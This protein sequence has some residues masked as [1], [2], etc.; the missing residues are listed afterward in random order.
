MPVGKLGYSLG[1]KYL[2]GE[3][4]LV[5]AEIHIHVHYQSMISGYYH[6]LVY[7]SPFRNRM[8]AYFPSGIYPKA[9]FAIS[10]SP[11]IAASQLV[12]AAWLDWVGKR[13]KHSAGQLK[14]VTWLK[15]GEWFATTRL[16]LV[17]G[18]SWVPRCLKNLFIPERWFVWFAGKIFCA[19]VQVE[20]FFRFHCCFW[21]LGLHVL[22]IYH[23]FLPGS[24]SLWS[25]WFC[26]SWQEYEAFYLLSFPKS[27]AW[28][29]Q[30]LC[31]VC[32][33]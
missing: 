29:L 32:S 13:H 18:S 31:L 3:E 8:H 22:H 4:V 5:A 11:F 26:C 16:V 23:N 33:T 28:V 30:N 2:L 10:P 19:C 1:M 15:S 24:S 20:L 9:L 21:L 12:S 25:Q 14:L 17:H 6:V 27:W 7:N